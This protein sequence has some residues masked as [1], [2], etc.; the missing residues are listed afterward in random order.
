MLAAASAFAGAT[1][2]EQPR[3]NAIHVD[4]ATRMAYTDFETLLVP[5][6]RWRPPAGSATTS[7]GNASIFSSCRQAARVRQCE[8]STALPA[9][10]LFPPAAKEAEAGESGAQHMFAIA[11]FILLYLVMPDVEGQA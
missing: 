3:I 5:G 4:N 6:R 9:G 8:R 7:S 11:A 2:A 10:P 1:D